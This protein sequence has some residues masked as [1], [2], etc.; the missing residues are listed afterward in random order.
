[1]K[2]ITTD[3]D[4]WIDAH[5]D[6]KIEN[7]KFSK[8]ANTFKGYALNTTITDDDENELDVHSVFIGSVRSDEEPT[9]IINEVLKFDYSKAYLYSFYTAGSVPLIPAER[10]AGINITSYI[11]RFAGEYT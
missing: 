9:D 5:P 10:G 7:T 6:H 1:M 3:Y 4:K 11:M 8:I 2:N